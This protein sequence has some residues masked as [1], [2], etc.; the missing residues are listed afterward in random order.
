MTAAE[1][2]E[3]LSIVVGRRNRLSAEIDPT[4]REAVAYLTGK[5]AE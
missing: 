1:S 5:D 3:G 2:M 4:R